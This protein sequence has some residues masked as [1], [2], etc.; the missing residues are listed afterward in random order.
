MRSQFGWW[1]IPAS[2]AKNGLSHRVPLA[3]S[4]LKII[5]EMKATVGGTS[6]KYVR[7]MGTEKYASLGEDYTMG[8]Y[9]APDRSV[10]EENLLYLAE[11]LKQDYGLP[12]VAG[13]S[14]K[15]GI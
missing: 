4:A 5:R 7:K 9:E 14:Q 13:S 6:S 15:L 10:W 2:K 8:D 11:I 1:T 12:A 3:Q